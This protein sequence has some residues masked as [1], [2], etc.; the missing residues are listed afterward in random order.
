MDLI[1]YEEN[2]I[3][4]WDM[5]KKNDRNG[6]LLDL[7]QRPEINL[8]SIF[9]M[10]TNFLS[11][12]WLSP[13]SHKSNRVDFWNFFE[14]YGKKYVAPEI[15]ERSKQIEKTVIKPE[16]KYGWISP[17]GR[18]FQCEFQGH[19]ALADNICF[20]IVD[21]NNSERYLEEHGWCK[22]YRPVT[23]GE[24]AVYVEDKLTDKQLHRLA[25][26]GLDNALGV[27]EKL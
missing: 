20:G 9:I 19:V 2:G 12:I 3:R 22:I 15:S 13:Q 7:M 8:H 27:S 11:G 1:C 17:D 21:T 6:F 25:K 23:Q 18:Y 16:T 5:I 24:Y 14:D 26:M 4:R 10:P